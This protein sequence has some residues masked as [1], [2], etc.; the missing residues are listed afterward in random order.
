MLAR[1]NN[2]RLQKY[3]NIN[4]DYLFFYQRWQEMLESKT[5][6]MY[7]Y[8]ILNSCVAC[9]ELDDVI[10]KTISGLF[11]SRQN[12]DD[13]K[14][15]TLE[16]LKLDDVLEKHNK[17][18]HITLLRI[19]GTKVG[20]K[21]RTEAIEDRRSSFFISLKRLKYQLESPIRI[22][23]NVYTEYIL[24]ELKRD[25]DN[26]DYR[27]IEYHMN[28]AIS[29]CIFE[30]WSSKGL[31]L[32]S[33]ILEGDANKE[34]K[35][36]RFSA[37][38]TSK[39]D[40]SFEVYY[41]IRIKT[42]RGINPTSV[43]EVIRSL[44]LDLK[45]G[46]EINQNVHNC[47]NLYT[48][49]NSD[50]NYIVKTINSTDLYSAALSAINILNSR[51]SVATFYNI[52]DPWIASSPQIIIYDTV[53]NL[54]ESLAITDV[55][56]TYD[57]IDSNNNI[58]EDTKSIINDPNKIQVMNKLHA[59]FAYTNLSRASYFQETKYISLWIAIESMMNTGLYPDNIS[60]VKCVLPEILCIRYLYRIVRNF[61]EDCIRCNFKFNN[62]LNINMESLD[63]KELVKK[64]I[65]IFRNSVQYAILEDSCKRNELLNY[66]CKEIHDILN[67]TTV[68]IGKFEHYSKKIRWH[69]Q[70]L[71]RIR[72]EITHSAFQNNKSLMIYIEH[73]YTYLSQVM[74]EVVY[75]I[76]HKNVGSIEEAF[77]II[78]ESY[79]TYIDLIKE[80]CHIPIHDI[81][82]EG[83]IDIVK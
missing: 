61:S 53:N 69:I 23:K 59:A 78:L 19:L 62:E 24:I 49:I 32:L 22:L 33:K 51:L 64:L 3:K 50:T 60:H 31:F 44:D 5:L 66:R 68:I 63:K 9:I 47:H 35:W 67:S 16:I 42:G 2:D 81:L 34:A 56:K 40:N 28:M 54:A 82:P 43:R 27:Q 25:I 77:T 29:Q 39:S 83:V 41:S 6:D 58:F 55:F 38:L 17:L 20:K 48:K 12:I 76:E 71:Y 74:S 26:R 7:Q 14:A 11:T 46:S 80:D 52:I 8:N 18:L 37:K 65:A 79:N 72:N 75:Y 15:E 4:D 45:R 30:G 10:D 73:L 13:A 70:R 1:N 21:D 36:N 57:Y